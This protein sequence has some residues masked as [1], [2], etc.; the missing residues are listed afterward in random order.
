[1]ID[2]SPHVR[3]TLKADSYFATTLSGFTDASDRFKVFKEGEAP[4]LESPFITVDQQPGDQNQLTEWSTPSVIF[5]VHGDDTNWATLWTIARKIRDVFM[6]KECFASVDEADPV[7][8]QLMGSAIFDHGRNPVT[9]KVL[10]SIALSFGI[11]E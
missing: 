7:R 11:T 6:E 5:S 4:T 9:E 10:V 1:M 2:L 3:A 8:Y